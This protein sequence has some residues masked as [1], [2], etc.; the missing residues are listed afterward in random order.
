MLPNVHEQP[1]KQSM[2]NWYLP[3]H[4]ALHGALRQNNSST[5]NIDNL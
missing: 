3:L 2:C 1:G 5:I 4:P